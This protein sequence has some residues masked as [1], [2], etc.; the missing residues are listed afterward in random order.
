MGKQIWCDI[1]EFTSLRGV[2]YEIFSK[3]NKNF[4]HDYYIFS[5]LTKNHKF[6]EL[7]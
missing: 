1:I 5:L 6:H 7:R 4:I 3:L 2:T